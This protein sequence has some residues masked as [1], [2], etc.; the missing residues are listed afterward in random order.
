MT[1]YQTKV[2]YVNFMLNLDLHAKLTRVLYDRLHWLQSVL[3]AQ[4]T[5]T[6]EMKGTSS[7]FNSLLLQANKLHYNSR[8]QKHV[9]IANRK[10]TTKYRNVLQ[11][12]NASIDSTRK[13]MLHR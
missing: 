5:A 3:A 6:T 7:Q 13:S 4:C 11:T 9:E 12:H 2:E 8:K 1:V 10:N